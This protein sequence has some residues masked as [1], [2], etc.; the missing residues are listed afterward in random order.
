MDAKLGGS[1]QRQFSFADILQASTAPVD[2]ASES[3]VT[4]ALD[5]KMPNL[6]KFYDLKELLRLSKYSGAK[7]EMEEILKNQ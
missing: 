5:P 3:I 2:E 7:E 4:T 1:F 6:K